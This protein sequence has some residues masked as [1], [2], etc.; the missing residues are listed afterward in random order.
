MRIVYVKTPSFNHVLFKRLTALGR[1]FTGECPM[2]LYSIEEKKYGNDGITV[3]P[4]PFLIE[5]IKKIAGEENVVVK[6]MNN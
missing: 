1:I 3:N 2:V 5:N 4:T 6:Y